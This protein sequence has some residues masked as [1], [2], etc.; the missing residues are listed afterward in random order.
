MSENAD[1]E[2]ASPFKTKDERAQERERKREA[3]LLAAV[4]LF[5]ARGFYAASLD[6]LAT[7]ISEMIDLPA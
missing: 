7:K 5:N 6:D 2:D 3:V 1:V 4:R